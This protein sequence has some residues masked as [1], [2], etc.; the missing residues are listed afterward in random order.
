M[1]EWF[2]LQYIVFLDEKEILIPPYSLFTCI[3]KQETN[4]L[5]E[6]IFELAIDNKA[7]KFAGV[8]NVSY[9]KG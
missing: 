7:E 4:G 3:G 9:W 1:L 6:L 2:Q 8:K 5:R